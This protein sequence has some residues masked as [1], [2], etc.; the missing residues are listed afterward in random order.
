MLIRQTSG[1]P[2]AIGI[3]LPESIHQTINDVIRQTRLWTHEKS[4]VAGELSAHFQ[5]GLE[6]GQ[7]TEELMQSFGPVKTAARLIRRSRLRCR[8]WPWQVW[9]RS[10]Q[11]AVG[12]ATSIFVCWMALIVPFRSAMPNITFDRVA[13][14]DAIAS[15]IPVDDRAWPLYRQGL[16]KLGPTRRDALPTL[17]EETRTVSV[18]S[19]LLRGPESP[20]WPQAVEFLNV[21]AESVELFLRGTERAQFGFLHRSSDN[22]DWIRWQTGNPNADA[23]NPPGTLASQTLLEHIQELTIVRSFIAG[24]MFSA[25]EENDAD[26][27]LRC[28][29]GLL[30]LGEHARED[31]FVISGQVGTSH[32]RLAC[33]CLAWIVQTR[34]QLFDDRQL[35]ELDSRLAAVSKTDW[36]VDTAAD[37][38]LFFE[39]FLQHA[40]SS[41][42]RFTAQGFR[43]LRAAI[44]S[45]DSVQDQLHMDLSYVPEDDGTADDSTPFSERLVFDVL[46]SEAAAWIA[47]H[48]EIERKF[49]ELQ[50]MRQN[51]IRNEE[52]ISNPSAYDTEL[53]RL[54]DSWPLRRRFLP[55]LVICQSGTFSASIMHN[56]ELLPLRMIATR[57]GAIVAIAL[58]RYHRDNNKWPQHLSELQPDYLNTLPADPMSDQPLQ[59]KL[60]DDVPHLHSVG[61]DRVDDGG[62]SVENTSW[63]SEPAKGDWRLLP[64]SLD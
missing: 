54:N 51:E 1:V 38:Q 60:I 55:I 17:R 21:H 20:S 58:E 27:V 48:D 15:E 6:S 14:L 28:F 22:I 35:R 34:P 47:D 11:C 32:V 43:H 10:W 33:K 13:E 36:R 31:G 64:V 30:K 46:G 42:G 41:D 9:R 39:D 8:P 50:L 57:D 61:P 40:Y 23:Y 19:A 16:M 44:S 49:V 26:I 45:M 12:V 24:R 5:D 4:D 37:N 53:A 59:F 7:S 63:S 56:A 2:A 18:Q 62:T 29:G 3:G 25:A 52:S